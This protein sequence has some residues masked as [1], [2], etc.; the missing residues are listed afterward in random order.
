MTVEPLNSESFIKIVFGKLYAT[1]DIFPNT[2]IFFCCGIHLVTKS[3]IDEKGEIPL[4]D[5]IK[6]SKRAVILIS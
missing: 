6:S 1:E 4:Q 2:Q 3:E 5:K